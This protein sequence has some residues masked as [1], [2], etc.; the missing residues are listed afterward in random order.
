MHTARPAALTIVFAALTTVTVVAQGIAPEWTQPQ[1]PFRIFGNTYYV[2][3]RGVAA[4]LITSDAG[5]VLVDVGLSEA[6]TMIA[7]NIRTLGFRVED[8]E[9]I[10][11]SHIHYDH[12]GGIGALQ[13][14]SGARVAASP[15]S[16]AVFKSGRSGPDDPQYGILPPIEPV[17]NVQVITDGESLRVGS[18]VVQAHFTGGHTPGGTSWT[19]RSC[20]ESACLDMVYA[21]SL[22]A[23]SA[24]AFLFSRNKTYPQAVADFEKSFAFLRKTPCDVLLTPHPDASLMWNRIERRENGARQA[25]ADRQCPSYADR[26]EKQLRTRLAREMK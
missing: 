20:E 18:L 13:R 9:L 10:V 5:H 8:V 24:D 1:A 3:T 17:A 22:T 15:S 12:A 14:L 11:N 7:A 16:A 6:A 2:G 23:V 19:W 21:D 4:I 26:A 25:L